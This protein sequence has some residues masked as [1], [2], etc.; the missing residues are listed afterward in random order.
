[1]PDDGDMMCF[2]P[3]A[4]DGREISFADVFYRLLV[5]IH[6]PVMDANN[7]GGH[8]LMTHDVSIH[9]PVMDAN[10]FIDNAEEGDQ[11]SIHAPVMDANSLRCWDWID[12]LF[13]STRP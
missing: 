3:R 4:R 11:V 8:L 7:D 13:Q 12:I 5:S 9:A 10:V 1:M 6:A 2:N